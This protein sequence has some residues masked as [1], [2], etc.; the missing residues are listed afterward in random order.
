V[1]CLGNTF[2]MILAPGADPVDPF[3]QRGTTFIVEGNLYRRG[4]IP[5]GVF[6]WD[7]SSAEHEGVELAHAVSGAERR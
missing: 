7:P 6:D 1:A 5:V 4:T 3:N 2:T